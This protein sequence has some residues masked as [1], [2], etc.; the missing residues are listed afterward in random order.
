[1]TVTIKAKALEAFVAD[2]FES[3]GCSEDEGGRIGRYLVSANL[4]GHD[5]HG[6]VRVPR[7]AAQKKNGTVVADVTVDVLV[8]TPVIAVVDGKYGFGQTVTPQ[9][10]QIGIA[11][12][13][14]NGLSAVTL[15]NAGHVGRVGDWAEMAA[16]AGLVSIHFVN[17][18]GSVLVAPYGGVQRRFSTAPYCVGVPR[19]A[20]CWCRASLRRACAPGGWPRA[21]RCPTT[22][23]PPSS[24]RRAP[25][26][27]TSG[28]SSRRQCSRHDSTTGGEMT[29]YERIT[30]S[31]I[32]G[33][34]GAEIGG[35]DIAAG[36]DDATIAEIRRA[37]LEHLVIFFRDQHLDDA[38][39]KAFSRRFGELFIH[40]NYDFGQAERE[41]V[42]VVRAPG[43]ERIVGEEWHTD[44]TM[45]RDPPMG[46]ILYAIEVPPY[47]GDTLFANQYLAYESLSD[48]MKAML[49][50]LKV[51]H[52]DI[53]VAGPQAGLN[54]RRS[55]KVREDANWQ[56]TENVHPA[57]RTHPETGRKCLFVNHSYSCR[58]D[59]MTDQESRPL[60]DFLMN[61]GHRPEF[62]CRF[63]WQAGSIAFWDN[64]CTKHLAVHDAGPFHRK[65]QRTQ[66]IGGPVA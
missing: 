15:R 35:V 42:R 55:S 30:V 8:D 25:S 4:S 27:L 10:V 41:I 12:C 32:A 39:H 37:L 53:R 17:A 60:L 36:L 47:G 54:A 20:R 24:K 11:K 2:I 16:E 61:H 38:S 62:T 43:D 63:R 13:R 7:Y 49:G 44:T 50:G 31:P 40:P 29:A 18:S 9:A 3:A 52:S 45:M 64:R 48:G 5:S 59:G 56:P 26:G 22:P 66:I 6:V 46:S 33:A 58:F 51:V 65:M 1:M 14:N 19:P 57:V 34:L 21:C 23:G 28:V